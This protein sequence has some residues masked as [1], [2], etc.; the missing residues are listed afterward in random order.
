MKIQSIFVV[1]FVL[2]LNA[3]KDKDAPSPAV[4]YLSSAEVVA[5]QSV[6]DFKNEANALGGGSDISQILILAKYDISKIKLT[7]KTTTPLGD[8]VIASGALFLPIGFE[9]DLALGMLAHGTLFNPLDAPSYFKSGTEGFAGTFLASTGMVIAMPD[10]LGYGASENLAHPYEHAEGLATPNIDFVRAVR[11]YLKQQNI[12]TNQ[13]VM[14]AGYS[15]GGYAGMAT[16]K[17]MEES[18]PTEFNVVAGVFGAGAYHKS[19]SFDYLINTTRTPNANYNRSYLWVLL[20]YLDLFYEPI[21]LNYIFKEPY[22][23]SIGQNGYLTELNVSL[24]QALNTAFIEDYNSGK[25]ANLKAF[26][27]E[28]DVF[29]WK[30]KANVKLIHGTA[31]EYVPYFNSADAYD[32]MLA[33]GATKVTL[34]P[35]EGGTHGSSISNYSISL[36]TTFIGFKE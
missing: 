31:D 11:E 36:I 9:G 35:V 8:S 24:N 34:D 27:A 4:K 23:T 21:A 17:K 2:F 33:K 32:A 13:R 25:L 15:E 18:F 12:S 5:N 16:Y 3:C 19:A 26:I 10:Y 28:N 7:Y 20:T 30:P 1:L 22:A 14:V 29:D 6:E